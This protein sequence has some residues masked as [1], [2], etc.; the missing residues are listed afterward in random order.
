MNR[1]II[2]LLCSGA[3][4]E[5]LRAFAVSALTCTLPVYTKNTAVWRMLQHVVALYGLL[6]NL[7]HYTGTTLIVV[8]I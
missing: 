3:H 2:S 8:P 4:I 6:V 7:Y 5:K 1:V